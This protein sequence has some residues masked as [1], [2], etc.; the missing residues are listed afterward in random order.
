MSK[1]LGNPTNAYIE[2]SES[3]RNHWKKILL[4]LL[5]SLVNR[6]LGAQ[7]ILKKPRAG[8]TYS[9]FEPAHRLTTSGPLVD[10]ASV[11]IPCFIIYYLPIPTSI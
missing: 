10:I 6:G 11:D 7:T 1:Y 8:Q 4:L 9:S 5:L 3:S 2:M